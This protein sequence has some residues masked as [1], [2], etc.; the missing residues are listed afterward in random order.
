M[1]A[2]IFLRTWQMFPYLLELCYSVDFCR[3]VSFEQ[4][5]LIELRVH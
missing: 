1:K 5:A 2:D 3:G 4:V